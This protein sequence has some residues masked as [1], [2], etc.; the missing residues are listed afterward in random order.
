[1]SAG[2]VNA[3][4]AEAFNGLAVPIVGAPGTV[5]E[6]VAVEAEVADVEPAVFVA[7]TAQ[8]IVLP[9]SAVTKV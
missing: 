9:T 1:L 5:A 7:V 8:L 6:T 4:E 3:T 2:A